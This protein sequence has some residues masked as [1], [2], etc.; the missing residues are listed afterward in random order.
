MNYFYLDNI[1]FLPL[2]RRGNAVN[3]RIGSSKQLVFIPSCYFNKNLTLK[4][5]VDLN[6]FIRKKV[7]RHKIEL[8][9]EEILN[10]K[11]NQ[12]I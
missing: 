7:I 5:N 11:D 8:F 4:E 3:C 9:K 1:P 2:K 12:T 6:W 10:E